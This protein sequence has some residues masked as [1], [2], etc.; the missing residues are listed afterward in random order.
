MTSTSPAS[1]GD[2]SLMMPTR[3][4]TRAQDRADRIR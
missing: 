3:V 2:R 4:R 1:G